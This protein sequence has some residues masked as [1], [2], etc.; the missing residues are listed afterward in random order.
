MPAKVLLYIMFLF[1]ATKPIQAKPTQTKVV[2]PP[3]IESAWVEKLSEQNPQKWGDSWW[4][5]TWQNGKVE[6]VKSPP[7]I[8]QNIK[9]V[10]WYVNDLERGVTGLPHGA[11]IQL[12]GRETVTY[13]Y[14]AFWSGQEWL[15][16]GELKQKA[17]Q[18]YREVLIQATRQHRAIIALQNEL[19]NQIGLIDQQVALE[20]L[21][22]DYQKPGLTS[23][24]K[25]YLKRRYK[26]TKNMI[27]NYQ[28]LLGDPPS[29]K[30][31]FPL[32][33]VRTYFFSE[34]IARLQ[35]RITDQKIHIDKIQGRFKQASASEQPKL[36]LTLWQLE[37]SLAKMTAML[38]KI[39]QTELNFKQSNALLYY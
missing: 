19:Q 30:K 3:N 34:E 31:V 14:P 10:R 25:D 38:N 20:T 16:E 2:R 23:Q 28:R 26:H 12:S 9:S 27:Q 4:V 37:Q 15:L 5:V 17:P 36:K 35:K 13:V 1:W 7:K 22:L 8:R 21:K 6:Q 33:L 32:T 24:E 29:V 39:Q 11:I 18:A